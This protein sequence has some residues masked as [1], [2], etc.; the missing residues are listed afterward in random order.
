MGLR[1][2]EEKLKREAI[3]RE[4]GTNLAIQELESMLNSIKGLHK[5]LKDLEKKFGGNLKSNPQASRKLME[6]REELGLPTELGIFEPKSKPGILDKLTGGGFYEQ[7]ALHI[8]EIGRKAFSETGGVI[9]FPE[10]IHRVQDYYKG[11]VVGISDINKAINVLEKNKLIAGVEE[12]ETGFKLVIFMT[13]E[14]SPDMNEIFRLANR[15]KGEL[16]R[17]EIILSTGWSLDRVNRVLQHL[18]NKNLIILNEDLEGIR[19]YFPGI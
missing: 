6:I 8:L 14:L 5:Q 13:Q 10:L 19:Y 7:L 4:K 2:I 11:H 17:E 18:E 3:M 12:L 1:K 15:N 16:S 9:S